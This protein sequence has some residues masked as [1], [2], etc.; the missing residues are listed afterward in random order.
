MVSSTPEEEPMNSIDINATGQTWDVNL[1][2]WFQ[3]NFTSLNDAYDTAHQLSSERADTEIVVH[4][5][6]PSP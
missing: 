5:N 6:T 4:G 2:G 3:G 1:N